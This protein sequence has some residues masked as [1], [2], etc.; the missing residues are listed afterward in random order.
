MDPQ[1]FCTGYHSEIGW[2]EICGSHTAVTGINFVERAVAVAGDAPPVLRACAQ[3]LEAYFA[4]R[5][6][7]F[8]LPLQ[9]QGTPFQQRVWR[10]LADIPFGQTVTYAELARRVGNPRGFRAVGNANG[11]NPVSIVIPCHRVVGSD[12]G[13]TGYGGGLW[14]KQWLLAHESRVRAAGRE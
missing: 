12:G 6:R 7:R 10:A 1:F 2:L 14:R 13:L 5:R 8:E 9:P 3:Q 11:K 4:G